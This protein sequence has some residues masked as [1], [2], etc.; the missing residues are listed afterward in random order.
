MML[1]WWEMKER[2][3]LFLTVEEMQVDLS[4]PGEC[5]SLKCV[6]VVTHAP[7]LATQAQQGPA[8]ANVS[9]AEVENL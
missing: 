6:D 9:C 5:C 8:S 7:S 2:P 1:P 3:T 4:Q